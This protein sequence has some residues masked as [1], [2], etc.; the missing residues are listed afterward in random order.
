MVD[1]KQYQLIAKRE[2]AWTRNKYDDIDM[3]SSMLNGSILKV[4]SD[5][6]IGTYAV[7]EYSLKG[8]T[9][10]YARMREICR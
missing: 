7:D 6:A 2:I 3:I 5:A 4:R 10:A 9:K 1:N 8:I